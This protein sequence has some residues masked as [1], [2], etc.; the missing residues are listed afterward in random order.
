MSI[1]MFVLKV[2][3]LNCQFNWTVHVLDYS[4][5]RNYNVARLTNLLENT[6]DQAPK[7]IYQECAD[8]IKRKVELLVAVNPKHAYLLKMV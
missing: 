3:V 1:L 8:S 5:I 4:M 6:K 7:D 2:K